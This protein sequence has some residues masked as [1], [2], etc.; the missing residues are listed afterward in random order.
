MSFPSV[1][2]PAL[3]LG[4]VALALVACESKAARE[5]SKRSSVAVNLP[6]TPSL[7]EKEIRRTH[8]DGSW[9][10]EGLLQAGPKRHGQSVRVKGQVV[11]VKLCPKAPP[12]SP[13]APEGTTPPEA[14]FCPRP[15]HLFLADTAEGPRLLV[16]GS[17]ATAVGTAQVGA[18]LAV[19]GLFDVLSPDRQFIRQA[20]LIALEEPPPVE[21][22]G[23]G[24]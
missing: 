23:E 5:P 4:S 22:G 14:P 6:P 3:L 11:E 19:E 7:R 10:V 24:S 12:P 21:G 17:E 8:K 15:P 2:M 9:T 13:D 16:A 20:G 1:L 18:E